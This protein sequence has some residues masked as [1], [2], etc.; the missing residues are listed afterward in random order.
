MKLGSG[1]HRTVRIQKGVVGFGIEHQLGLEHASSYP[2]PVLPE[3]GRIKSAPMQ[4]CVLRHQDFQM[5]K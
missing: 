3:D 4:L 2:V 5:L 1:A